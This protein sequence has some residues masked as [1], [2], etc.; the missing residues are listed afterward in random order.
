MKLRRH[1][2]PVQRLSFPPGT[3]FVIWFCFCFFFPP[4]LLLYSFH[5]DP[6]SLLYYTLSLTNVSLF[7]TYNM[8]ENS[9]LERAELLGPEII[10]LVGLWS[11]SRLCYPCEPTDTCLHFNPSHPL[12]LLTDCFLKPGCTCLSVV[13]FKVFISIYRKGI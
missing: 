8:H 9:V 5:I 13:H 3:L 7:R 1:H 11:C 2:T 4:F 6:W 12:P 10:V